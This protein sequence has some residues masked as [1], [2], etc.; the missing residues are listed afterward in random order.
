ML[1]TCGGLGNGTHVTRSRK[2]SREEQRGTK[3]AES[4]REGVGR[5]I[6]ES[7]FCFKNAIMQLNYVCC[8]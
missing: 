6:N 5:S 4:G 3:E 1:R 7:L 2:E 8:G